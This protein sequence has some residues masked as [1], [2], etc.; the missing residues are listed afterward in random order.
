MELK[1]LFEM[2]K[3]LDEHIMLNKHW[4]TNLDVYLVEKLLALQVEVSELANATRCFKYWSEKDSE[5][6][7]RLLDEYADVLHFFLSVG[8]ALEFTPEEVEEAYIKKNRI[9][10]ERQEQGY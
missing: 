1:E 10:H 3:K 7:E 4:N 6:K 5:S 8:L 2:Q 9:N